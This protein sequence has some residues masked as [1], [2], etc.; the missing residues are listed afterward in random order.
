MLFVAGNTETLRLS[1]GSDGLG[2]DQLLVFLLE[3][4]SRAKSVVRRPG[5]GGNSPRARTPGPEEAALRYEEEGAS[6]TAP[7]PAP[8]GPSPTL[9]CVSHCSCPRFPSP[10]VTQPL[11]PWCIRFSTMIHT[12]NLSS[13][14]LT[15]V[16]ML[17]GLTVF[18]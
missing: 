15:C 3:E 10:P 16:L 5:N 11:I 7:R 6:S 12:F 18:V 13:P 17:P 14:C 4:I 1:G 9:L 8:Q 2:L